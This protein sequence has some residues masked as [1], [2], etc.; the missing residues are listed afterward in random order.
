[1]IKNILPPQQRYQPGFVKGLAVVKDRKGITKEK[2]RLL[3][4]RHFY[5]S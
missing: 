1:M 4:H 2:T 3:D 5:R